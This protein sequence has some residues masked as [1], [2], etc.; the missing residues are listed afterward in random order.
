MIP[1]PEISPIHSSK[2][3]VLSPAHKAND[4]GDSSAKGKP[5]GEV[6]N[7][8]EQ[9]SKSPVGA[10]SE[11]SQPTESGK[12]SQE[13]GKELPDQGVVD[14][15]V[16][17][18]LQDAAEVS[19][20]DIGDEV[21]LPIEIVGSQAIPALQNVLEKKVAHN[22]ETPVLPASQKLTDVLQKFLANPPGSG[23]GTDTT[24]N[25]GAVDGVDSR[26]ARPAELRESGVVPGLQQALTAGK[27]A[28]ALGEVAIEM[29]FPGRGDVEFTTG[30]Q[31]ALTAG[32]AA[33]ALGEVAIEMPFP[34]R[35]DV[36]FTTGLQQALSAGKA[37]IALESTEQFVNLEAGLQKSLPSNLPPPTLGAAMLPA[38]EGGFPPSAKSSLM[39][40]IT[41]PLGA[42]GWDSEF[43]G[44]MSVM[45][46]SGVQEASLQ[47]S[48]PGLGRLEVKISTEGDQT[49]VMF[50]VESA[51]AK[52]AIEQAM[53]RLREMLEQGGLELAQSEVKDHSQSQ[54]GNDNVTELAEESTVTSG[55]DVEADT[56]PL[57]LEVSSST[58]DYYI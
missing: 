25:T 38:S 31:Q 32:K 3:G 35:G 28:K 22:T 19:P 4:H 53:P 40:S 33:K 47:L 10:V 23:G 7:S 9:T 14:Q 15:K 43:V 16:A 52:D 50:A 37:A 12:L 5:F 11:S 8:Q 58:V 13:G 6:L 36:E 27:A 51:V 34:G 44:R 17:S 26:L 2:V 29:P 49:K 55:E 18:A 48:P 20:E 41:T 57:M 39:P 30:L 21:T 54:Q 45:V 46:K 24:G 1:T 56:T 42:S